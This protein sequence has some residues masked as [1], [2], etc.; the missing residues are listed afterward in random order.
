MC[1][2]TIIFTTDSVQNGLTYNCHCVIKHYEGK[3]NVSYNILKF[4]LQQ[5]STCYS[6]VHLFIYTKQLSRTRL[7][8]IKPILDSLRLIHTF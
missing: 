4:H 5:F 1:I 2:F 8:H 6:S 3:Q 7:I